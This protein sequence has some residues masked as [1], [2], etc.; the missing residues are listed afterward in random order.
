VF[1]IQR[2]AFDASDALEPPLQRFGARDAVGTLKGHCNAN[3]L[4]LS[5]KRCRQPKNRQAHDNYDTEPISALRRLW[6]ARNR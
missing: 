3:E 2:D 5:R 6:P 4:G 1:E